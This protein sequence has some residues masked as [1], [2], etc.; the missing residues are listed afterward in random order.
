MTRE[1]DGKVA[2]V[3]GGG[4]GIGRATA[5][6]FAKAGAKV[7]IANR[8]VPA[9]EE[10]ARRITESGGW[11]V[12]VRTDVTKAADV[13][14]MVA[15]TV[16]TFG[17]LDCAFNNAGATGSGLRLADHT[18]EAFDHTVATNLKGVW[19]CMKYEILQMLRQGG[20]A[21]VNCASVAG[22]IG[23]LVGIA[24]V[25]SKFGVVGMSRAAAREYAKDGIRVNAVC[26]GVT[27]TAMVDDFS[28]DNPGWEDRVRA[29]YPM[30]R[31][32][33][34]EEVANA[35][36]WLCS[37]GASFISGHALPVDGGRLA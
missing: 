33:T 22:L 3:T 12:F 24:Y 1:L 28:R 37:D 11:A 34:P 26:P 13:E 6:A 30:G 31:I 2:L 16:Q 9:G 25:A 20:G 8:S 17:R 18:E 4:S 10:T 14:T 32:G 27:R 23:G 15:T 19:L 5:V 21:L 35:V 7:V 36:V 29:T